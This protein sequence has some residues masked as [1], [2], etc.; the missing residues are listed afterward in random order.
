[1]MITTPYKTLVM[2]EIIAP[3]MADRTNIL[4]PTIPPT[5][6]KSS[7]ISP[8]FEITDSK[9]MLSFYIQAPVRNNWVEVEATLINEDTGKALYFDDGVEYYYG[10]D[11]DGSWSEGS[12]RDSKEFTALP[13]GKYHLVFFEK[14]LETIQSFRKK[15]ESAGV[16]LASVNKRTQKKGFWNQYKQQKSSFLLNPESYNARSAG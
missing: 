10:Y 7:M 11:S 14:I 3:P 8:T 4:L 2:G 13:K 15:I 1:M 5:E 9:A 16:W 12:Q 6:A